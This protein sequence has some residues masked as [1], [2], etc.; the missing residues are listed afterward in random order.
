VH[1]GAGGALLAAFRT[2]Q[3]LAV[4]GVSN[5]AGAFF[6]GLLPCRF[7]TRQVARTYRRALEKAARQ[8][9]A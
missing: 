1:R 6:G 4:P 5:R 7:V 2:R 8:V 9:D 3:Y